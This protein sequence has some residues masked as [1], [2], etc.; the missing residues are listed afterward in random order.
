MAFDEGAGRV[1][2]ITADF[3]PRP[4]ATTQNPRPRP[5]IVPGSFTVLVVGR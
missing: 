1:Y 2:L 3:G 4:A 5:Q